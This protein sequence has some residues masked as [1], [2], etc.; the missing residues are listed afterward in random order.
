MVGGMATRAGWALVAIGWCLQLVLPFAERGP[1]AASTPWEAVRFAASGTMPVSVPWWIAPGLLVL[2]ALAVV[3]VASGFI[4]GADA[5][6]VACALLGA[7]C[8]L[9]LVQALGGVDNLAVGGWLVL[10]AAGVA[11]VGAGGMAVGLVKQRRSQ[12]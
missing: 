3:L 10:A 6:V 4:E 9:G 7:A 1:L 12:P 2:P 5:A 8:S 11:A